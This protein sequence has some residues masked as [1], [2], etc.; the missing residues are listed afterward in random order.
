MRA[1][2]VR[3]KCGQRQRE[4]SAETICIHANECV[5]VAGSDPHLD[6]NNVTDTLNVML[7]KEY[8]VMFANYLQ[9]Q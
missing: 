4:A 2:Q 7:L 9:K 5:V 3:A 1:Q 6:T 8:K